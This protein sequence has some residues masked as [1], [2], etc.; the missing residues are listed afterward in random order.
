MTPFRLAC[1][2]LACASLLLAAGCRLFPLEGSGRI[3]DLAF[4]G[5]Y[6]E[7]TA[8]PD[9]LAPGT[10]GTAEVELRLADSTPFLADRVY[11]EVD[12]IQVAEL[13]PSRIPESKRIRGVAPGRAVVRVR[14]SV[15][16]WDDEPHNG[17]DLYEAEL[18]R[19][20]VIHAST[21]PE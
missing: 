14:A 8:W 21:T 12:S 5:M 11:W 7:V 9:T 18:E 19:S 4:Q 15:H 3:S 6:L 1:C 13:Y 10:L 20:V 16:R 17:D 2:S